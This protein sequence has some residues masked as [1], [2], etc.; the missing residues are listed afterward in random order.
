MR[1][2]ASADRRSGVAAPRRPALG[3]LFGPRGARRQRPSGAPATAAGPQRDRQLTS[4]QRRPAVR[5]PHH[6]RGDAVPGA[7]GVRRRARPRS[8]AD[9][10]RGHHR[11]PRP[12]LARR[13]RHVRAVGVVM[14]E[15]TEQVQAVVRIANEH[16]VPLWTHSTG[17]NNGY[18]GPAPRVGGS[19][20]SSQ[21]A[22]HE[23][24]P[25]DQRRARL[26]G[27]RAGRALV[28][29]PRRA[30]RTAAT[31]S[32]SRSPTS[33]G[34]ASV[35]NS[36]DNGVTYLNPR[37]GLPRRLRH[38]GRPRRRL[39]PA[40]RHGRAWRATRPG[41]CT[42][43]ASARCSTRCSCS[44]TRDRHPDGRLAAAPARVL[45][46]GSCCGC[47][48]TRTSTRGWTSSAT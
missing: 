26:R 39:A 3:A 32:W 24:R 5:V 1:E 18:G 25:R 29:P 2:L 11:V 35:G 42:S 20:S 13:R 10:R 21:P 46:A 41:T 37:P 19:R 27:R 45:P 36:L 17:R 28:R 15:T 43:A 7:G 14:P 33:G 44:P 4:S 48:A 23:P 8:R 6:A 12:V 38:G 9:L 31:T 34:G 22:Q 47:G 16:G 40:H 30:R